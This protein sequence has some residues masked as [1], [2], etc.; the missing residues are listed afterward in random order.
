[1]TPEVVL[2]IGK[3]ALGMAVMIGAIPLLSALVVGLV[4]GMVQAAT[5]INE[6]TLT[7][8]PKLL[9]L[10]VALS[11]GGSWMLSRM[12]DYTRRLIESIPV[13]IG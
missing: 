6:M 4:I 3:E 9:V 2:A 1:M 13:L 7:F 5:Q 11:L 8:I 12:V 10:V